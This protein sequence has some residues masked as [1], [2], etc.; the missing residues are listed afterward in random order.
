MAKRVAV[1]TDSTSN[2]PGEAVTEHGIRVVPLRVTLGHRLAVDDG[3]DVTPADVTRA[4]REKFPVST[5]RPSPGEFVD[6]YRAALDDGAERVVSVHLSAALSGTWESAVLAAQEFP[7]GVVRV[8]DS[9]SSAMG[10]G[11][12]VLAAADEARRGGSAA[13]VQTAATRAVDAVQTTFCVDSLEYLRR[14]G[15][16]GTAAALFGTSL[17]IKPLLHMVEGRIVPLEKVRTSSRAVARLRDLAVAAAGS[18]PV[19]IAVHH[20]DADDRA[21]ALLDSLRSTLPALR[22]SSVSELGAVIGAHLGPGVLGIV[23]QRH[24][25]T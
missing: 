6:A 18:G 21:A 19:S 25:A 10:L 12:P 20:L 23:L 1:V 9:R 8:V 11:F 3:V 2:L 22:S 17:A 4:L 5:S 14:G 7:F 15:R 24:W 13:A 16:V